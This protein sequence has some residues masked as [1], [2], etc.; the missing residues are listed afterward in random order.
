MTRD[1]KFKPGDRVRLTPEAGA[2]TPRF[3]VIGFDVPAPSDLTTAADTTQRPS[4]G[5][6]IDGYCREDDGAGVTWCMTCSGKGDTRMALMEC[7]G[8]WYEVEF[9]NPGWDGVYRACD[10]VAAEVEE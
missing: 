1:F 5:T 3:R 7:P 2:A 6:I 4:I 10:L 9:D 8:P